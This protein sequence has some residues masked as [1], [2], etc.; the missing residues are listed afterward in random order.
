LVQLT[1]DKEK[2]KEKKRNNIPPKPFWF[3]GAVHDAATLETFS[4]Q[5]ES[6]RRDK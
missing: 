3:L 4:C 6:R 1:P 2:A 5:H